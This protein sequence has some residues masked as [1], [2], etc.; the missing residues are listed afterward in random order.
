MPAT[1]RV[2]NKRFRD[3]YGFSPDT[4]TVSILRTTAGFDLQRTLQSVID[5]R[6]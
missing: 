3:N 2:Y 4:D 6:P 1:G 5:K